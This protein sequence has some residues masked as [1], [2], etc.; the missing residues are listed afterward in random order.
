M[1]IVKIS[2]IVI[3]I[4]GAIAFFVAR[5][6][7]LP[8]EYSNSIEKYSAEYNLEPNLVKAVIKTESSYNPMAVSNMGAYGLMQITDQT[9]YYIASNI[10]MGDFNQPM[11][12]NP[13]VNIQMGCWYLR[14][15][16]NEFG[17]V[18]TAL[19]AYNAGR[20]NVAKWLKN[21]EYSSNQEELTKIPFKETA[22]YVKKV[23]F[24]EKL[25]TICYK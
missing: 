1:S 8:N 18:N 21:P 5:N 13:D 14:N 25:Y 24:Y 23:N 11:L 17:N 4:A 10:G 6:T 7:Y 16:I 9:G 15:L 12:Y 20:G 3:G 19:A 2:I 22:N